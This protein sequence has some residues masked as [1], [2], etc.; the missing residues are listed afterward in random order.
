MMSN[1][2]HYKCNQDFSLLKE[3]YHFWCIFNVHIQSELIFFSFALINHKENIYIF[4][5]T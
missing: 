4:F 5:F 3:I 1:L 2:M